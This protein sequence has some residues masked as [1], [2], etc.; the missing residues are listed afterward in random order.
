M[1]VDDGGDDV[2]VGPSKIHDRDDALRRW[3]ADRPDEVANL[4]ASCPDG[5]LRVSH[6]T[7]KRRT[8]PGAGRRFDSIW[9]S[10]HFDVLHIDYHYESCIATGS[11][12]A[13]VVADLTVG[14]PR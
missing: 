12:H 7:G 11:D 1:T 9:V 6:R 4:R 8:S 10:R 2:L 3:L 13:A 5:P 14:A